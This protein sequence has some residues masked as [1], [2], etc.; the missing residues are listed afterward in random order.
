MCNLHAQ[1]PYLTDFVFVEEIGYKTQR[2]EFTL[3]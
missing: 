3:I 2:N 1:R